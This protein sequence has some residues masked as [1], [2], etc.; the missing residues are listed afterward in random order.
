MNS[1]R[2]LPVFLL[3]V[4]TFSG[5]ASMNSD[6]CMTS[7][8]HAIG[9]EDGSR[10]YSADRLGNHRKAC[11][12]HGITPDFTAY[13][14][15]REQGLEQFCRPSRGF[16]LGSNGGSYN[17]VCAD[18]REGDFIDAFNSGHHL[19]SLRSRVN[20]ANNQI[21]YKQR[22]LK[23]NEDEMV[24][25]EAALISA[26]TTMEDRIRILAEL[27]NLSEDNGQ[28]DAEI[29]HLIEDRAKHE[30]ELANYQ[31]ILANSGY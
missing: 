8:W 12:K 1:K 10:G 18:H 27:K 3:A 2:L 17:G 7:D 4:I 31:A 14:D 20:S 5:C 21:S 11:A 24:A 16:S 15:G 29:I 23:E 13:H 26:D 6:E 28:L 19:Y 9:F 22:E 25:K 30:Q